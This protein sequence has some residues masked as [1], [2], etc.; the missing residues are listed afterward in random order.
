M[1]NIISLKTDNSVSMIHFELKTPEVR[2]G[3]ELSFTFT[4][5]NTSDSPVRLNVR[6]EIDFPAEDGGRV[7]HIYRI[8]SRKCPVGFLLYNHTHMI[9]KDFIRAEDAA[10]KDTDILTF[11]GS[12]ILPCRLHILV[13]GQILQ[14]ADFRIIK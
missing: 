4:L 9:P 8:S 11:P 2:P 3:E 7:C 1:D 10:S 5:Q 6:Y 14:S 12:R 13:N